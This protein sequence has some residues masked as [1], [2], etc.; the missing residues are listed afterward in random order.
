MGCGLAMRL[1]NP[2]GRHGR[3]VEQPIRARRVSPPVAGAVD[4]GLRI[5]RQ[6]FNHRYAPLVP[7]Y[8]PSAALPVGR[9]LRS[10][11]QGYYAFG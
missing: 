8:V 1:Q 6:S 9:L 5:R 10:I 4:A 3:V 2:L 11:P 7:L